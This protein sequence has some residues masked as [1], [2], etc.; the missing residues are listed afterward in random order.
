MTM[1]TIDTS[2]LAERVAERIEQMIMDQELK[3]G[4][5]LG[6]EQELVAQLGTGRGT[7]REA[8]KILESR[9]VVEIR[10]GKGTFVCE[11]VGVAKDPFGFRF[12]QDK[13]KLAVDLSALRYMLEPPIASLA[14][15][16]ASEQDIE[17]LQALCSEVADLIQNG[18]D[19]GQKDIEFHT[20]IAAMTGNLVIPQIVPII[21]QAVFTYVH[22]TN[23]KMA[24][25]AASEHQKVVDAIRNH[26][27]QAAYDAMTEHMQENKKNLNTYLNQP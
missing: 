13:I 5:K 10:R 21:T 1:E 23:H 12:A 22:M 15:E 4:D 14:A 25:S 16:K 7:I 27:P 6:N 2:S 9:N 24:G 18:E 20:K 26:D 11:K 8:V 17:E 19:Y 3:P